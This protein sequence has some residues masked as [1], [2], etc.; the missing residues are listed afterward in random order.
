MN[1]LQAGIE[2]PFAVLAQPAALFQLS[3]GAFNDPAFGQRYKCMRF[4]AL[5][6]LHGGFQ[7]LLYVTGELLPG[8]A[9]IDRHAFNSLQIRPPAVDNLQGSAAI[10]RLGCGNRDNMGQPRVSTPMRRLMPE[11]FLPAPYLFCSALSVF[12][13]L[14]ASTI[15]KQVMALRPCLARASP[16][17][18]LRPAPGRRYR[19]GLT[20]STWRSRN[21]PHATGEIHREAYAA[22]SRFRAGTTPR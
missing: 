13:T 12:F 17:D 1:E 15:K 21:A 2:F 22:G 19:P 20:R 10:S 14:C 8:V 6:D 3:E 11:T 16:T 5:D 18:Y 4:I 7:A 9:A